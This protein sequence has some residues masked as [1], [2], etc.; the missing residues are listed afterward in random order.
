MG[1]GKTVEVLAL[2]LANPPPSAWA[3]AQRGRASAA[4][5]VLVPPALL[6]QWKAEV[7]AKAPGLLCVEWLAYRAAGWKAPLGR[8]VASV[9]LASYVQAAQI[10]ADDRVWWRVV[11]DEPHGTLTATPRAGFIDKSPALV[12][13]ASID[14]GNRWCMTG[15]PFSNSLFEVFGSTRVPPPHRARRHRPRR[16]RGRAAGTPLPPASRR[17]RPLPVDSQRLGRAHDL[18]A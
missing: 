4:T 12:A 9:V 15:T 5:L 18:A 1:M 11:C 17:R 6:G 7:A 13:S 14:G 8:C 10:A 16:E 2:M 3:A